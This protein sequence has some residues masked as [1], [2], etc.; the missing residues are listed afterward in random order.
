MFNSCSFS[1]RFHVSLWAF[2]ITKK[3]QMLLE[4]IV[5]LRIQIQQIQDKLS[6][7]Q[8]RQPLQAKQNKFLVFAGSLVH[9]YKRGFHMLDWLTYQE[10]I[11]AL[12]LYLSAS[13]TSADIYNYLCVFLVIKLKQ[14]TVVVKGNFVYFSQRDWGAW[15]IAPKVQ[16][17]DSEGW[18]AW[19][20]AGAGFKGLNCS[21]SFFKFIGEFHPHPVHIVTPPELRLTSWLRMCL[22]SSCIR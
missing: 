10:G 3:R 6:R 12:E 1:F 19:D 15:D 20:I 18:G 4:T 17:S 5:A 9:V 7:F 11:L 8:Q 21:M 2:I 14:S 16:G 13:W 22:K